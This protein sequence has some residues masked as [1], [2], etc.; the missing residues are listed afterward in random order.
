MEKF[1]L[2]PFAAFSHLIDYLCI[3]KIGCS[4]VWKR[5]IGCFAFELNKLE[6]DEN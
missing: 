6:V 3:S 5:W 2:L 1:F 4:R